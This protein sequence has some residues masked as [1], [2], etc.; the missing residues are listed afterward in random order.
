MTAELEEVVVDADARPVQH[1]GK[2]TAEDLLMRRARRTPGAGAGE[3]RG[4]QRA[5]IELAVG[6]EGQLIGPDECGH[7][8]VGQRGG[9]LLTLRSAE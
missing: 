6:S 9:T 5:A 2:E 7:H 8:V 3:V 1:F 4:R